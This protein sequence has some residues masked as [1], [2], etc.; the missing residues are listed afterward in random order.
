MFY[1]LKCA[2]KNEG[3]SFFGLPMSLGPC[4]ICGKTST[5]YDVPSAALATRRKAKLKSAIRRKAKL[6]GR[7]IS[8]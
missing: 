3:P 8:V 1:C 4:E 2:K 6:K 7:R 5:C